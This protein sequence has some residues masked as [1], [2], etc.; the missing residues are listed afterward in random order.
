[1]ANISIYIG[2]TT[3]VMSFCNYL[4]DHVN[5]HTSMLFE[6]EEPIHGK[7]IKIYSGKD[8]DDDIRPKIIS[9]DEV[10]LQTVQHTGIYH[11]SGHLHSIVNSPKIV[12]MASYI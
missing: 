4:D 1:M 3:A 12:E 6:C 5:E 11:Q 8:D 9:L 2:N 10:S 7:F